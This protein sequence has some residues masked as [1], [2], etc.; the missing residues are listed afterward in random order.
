MRIEQNFA[1]QS[2]ILHHKAKL[3]NQKQ[4]FASQYTF[5]HFETKFFVI[6]QKDLLVLLSKA[7][8][9]IAKQHFCVM[10]KMFCEL[11]TSFASIH[12][13]AQYYETL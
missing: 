2:Q 12:Y 8:F 11:S 1:S 5:L 6:M 9:C 4:I 3:F 7:K 13:K 10:K